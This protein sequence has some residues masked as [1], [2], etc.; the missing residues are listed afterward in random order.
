M[1]ILEQEQWTIGIKNSTRA[2]QRNL[3]NISPIKV[4]S[5]IC[6]HLYGVGNKNDEISLSIGAF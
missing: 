4:F 5:P 1:N 3:V 2:P 6:F